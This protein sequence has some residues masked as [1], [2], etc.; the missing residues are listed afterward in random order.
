MGGD[1]ILEAL[2]TPPAY[3]AEDAAAAPVFFAVVDPT[4]EAKWQ[5]K[6]L[7]E[8][9]QRTTIVIK[10]LKHMEVS[11][12]KKMVHIQPQSTIE[13]NLLRLCQ[14]ELFREVVQK[15]FRWTPGRSECLIRWP[16]RR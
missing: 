1:E 3:G 16:T 14:P 8:A 13:V 2:A 6:I 12:E 11:D 4:P 7:H 15:L 10:K 9:P 5:Q